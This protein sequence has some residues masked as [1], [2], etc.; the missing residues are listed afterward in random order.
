MIATWVC[1]ASLSK[2]HA[3][4]L[5]VLSVEARTRSLIEASGRFALQLLD[6]QQ[7]DLVARFALPFDGDRFAGVAAGATAT[8]LP[9]V[10]GGCGF[11]ECVVRDSLATGD[12]VVYLA[13]IVEEQFNADR[14]PLRERDALT[15]Q[16]DTV[17]SALQRSYELDVFRDDRLLGSAGS[18]D[19]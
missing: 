18:S 4:V 3:R 1:Q 10:E 5:V 19:E 16:P 12:R 13:E 7:Q 14:L 8:G 11:V 15:E 17:A 9:L 2:T 6:R